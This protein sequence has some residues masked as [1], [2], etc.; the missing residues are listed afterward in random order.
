ML[1]YMYIG[2]ASGAVPP[3]GGAS[4]FQVIFTDPFT[5]RVSVQAN[6]DVFDTRAEAQAWIRENAGEYAALFDVRDMFDD[7]DFGDD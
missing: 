2:T 4:M 1:Y 5:S 7:D 6:G 3:A